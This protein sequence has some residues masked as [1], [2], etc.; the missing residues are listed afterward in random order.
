MYA[1]KQEEANKKR[2][3]RAMQRTESQSFLYP[4]THQAEHYM[5]ASD[6]TI[7]EFAV[8]FA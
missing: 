3:C 8:K 5:E 2:K 6:V 7:T 4:P 1:K